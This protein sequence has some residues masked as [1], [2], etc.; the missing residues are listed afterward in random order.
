MDS[1]YEETKVLFSAG[2]KQEFT[3]SGRKLIVSG[4]L[5][6]LK[7]YSSASFKEDDDD[8]GEE[9][10]VI[11]GEFPAF[12]E[13]EIIPFVSTL[14]GGEPCATLS[15]K[16]GKTSPPG[17]LTESE[18]IS[19][20]EKHG[21]GTDASI[22]THINNICN[23]NYVTLEAGRKLVPTQLGTVLVQGYHRIDSDLV[24]P[25]VRSTIEQ[26]CNYIAEGKADK[27][28]V[29]K[30]ALKNFKSKFSYFR[31][32]IARMEELFGS[33]FASIESSG[34]VWTRCGLT[35]R[36][37]NFIE[38]P[39]A[40][41]YNRFTETVY[42]LPQGGTY[43]Q[44]NG[45]MCETPGCRFELTLYSVGSPA[46]TYPLCPFCYNNPLPEWGTIPTP[47]ENDGEEDEGKTNKKT[48]R[49][50]MLQCPH[51][52]NHPLVKARQVST[53]PQ[54]GGVWILDA[55]PGSKWQFVSTRGN[56]VLWF[57]KTLVKKLLIL[58]KKDPESGSHFVQI[59][60]N[61]SETP[62]EDGATT[63]VG[64]PA[65]DEFIHSLLKVHE[66]SAR[67]IGSKSRGRGRGRGRGGRSRGRGR[68]L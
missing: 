62:L 50:L 25:R 37:M 31:D 3:A 11:D 1:Q 24:L 47:K 54:S 43:S 42:S 20:M 36:F 61:K 67:K 39:P 4:F 32:S 8:E 28:V 12:T 63:Y 26:Q 30:H 29:V 5:E 14:S 57:P 64:C 7:G 55:K 48:P 33:S 56:V 34:Q 17:Y 52:D 21:I 13:N 59:E 18:L 60:F 66:G 68:R 15:I 44:G 23:R 22:P 46:R 53:D 19:L 41:L 35:K 38:G 2:K 45:Q 58:K 49:G 40:R 9:D 16:E 65:N 10:D 6:V 51:P 27:E